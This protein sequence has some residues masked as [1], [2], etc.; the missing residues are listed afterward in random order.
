MEKELNGVVESFYGNGQLQS[1]ANYKDGNLDGL[2]E[3]WYDNGQLR[4]RAN[5]KDDTLDGLLETWYDNGQL[6]TRETYKDGNLDGLRET[7]RI[8]G[9][10]SSSANYKDG[11][12]VEYVPNKHEQNMVEQ[13]SNKN[14]SEEEL[15]RLCRENLAMKIM[16]LRDKQIAR[17]ITFK[18][19]LKQLVRLIEEYYENS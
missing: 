10:L 18:E 3:V 5:Y 14:V 8:N 9:E 19:S 2:C 6:W 11:K 16:L 13:E 7:W 1:R 12:V 4:T 15:L 17:E